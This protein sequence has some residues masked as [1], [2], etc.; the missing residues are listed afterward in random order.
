MPVTNIDYVLLL[1]R[2]YPTAIYD[3]S[4]S[5]YDKISW[6]DTIPKPSQAQLDSEWTILEV[7]LEMESQILLLS[8]QAGADVV[9]GFRSSALGA[10]YIYDSAP[11]D[12]LNLIGMV[13][14]LRET[15]ET[16]KANA[17]LNNQPAPA[18]PSDYFS[19][20]TNPGDIQK[21]YHLHTLSQ[22]AQVMDDGKIFKLQ[23]LQTFNIKKDQVLACVDIPSIRAITWTPMAVV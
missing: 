18:E 22:L 20:R 16:A 10:P 17:I 4:C 5:T 19:T 15:Y 21:T 23:V 13:T 7:Q 12:Q 11:E 2:N 3:G 9:K 1:E 8:Q 14:Q 6:K